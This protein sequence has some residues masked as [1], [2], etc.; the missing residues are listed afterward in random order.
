MVAKRAGRSAL[1]SSLGA[2][3]GTYIF[4]RTG[5]PELGV[6]TTAFVTALFMGIG[7]ALRQRGG[8][9]SSTVGAIF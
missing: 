7:K 8:P 4:T 6:A 1:S 3:A 5:Q 9:I 2:I